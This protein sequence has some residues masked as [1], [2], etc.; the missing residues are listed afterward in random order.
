MLLLLASGCAGVDWESRIGTYTYQDAVREFGPPDQR[1]T[2]SDGSITAS[3]T[4]GVGPNWRDRIIMVF[5][6]NETLVSVRE[7]R[8]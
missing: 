4:T 8:L 6:R 3:W 5:G 1:E 7:V 2:L